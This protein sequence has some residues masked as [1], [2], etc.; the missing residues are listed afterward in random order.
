M[1]GRA[2][3]AKKAAENGRNKE[4]YNISKALAGELRRQKV[5]VKDK[6]GEIKKEAQERLQR[7]VEHFSE[8]LN[9]DIAMNPV[10]EDGGE[11]LEE[12]EE[13]DLKRWR[14]TRD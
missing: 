13:K 10:E 8:I 14:N 1:E 6:Q 12:I 11:E 9:R 5:G 3:A 7:W 2:A 4:Q